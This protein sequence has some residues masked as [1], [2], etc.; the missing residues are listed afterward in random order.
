MC[1]AGAVYS[2]SGC[3]PGP[4]SLYYFISSSSSCVLSILLPDIDPVLAAY[5]SLIFTLSLPLSYFYHHHSLIILS[6]HYSLLA[7]SLILS[8]SHSLILLSFVHLS[9]YVGCS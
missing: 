7:H 6:G 9:Y 1:C 3:R 2:A 5:L 8:L 4:S